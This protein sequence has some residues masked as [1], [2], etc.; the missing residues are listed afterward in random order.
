MDRVVE[1]PGL[2]KSEGGLGIID[3]VLKAKIFHGQWY[4]R[5]LARGAEP[6]KLLLRARIARI[7]AVPQSASDWRWLK[8]HLCQAYEPP[9]ECGGA[10]G[11][12]GCWNLES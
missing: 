1:W 6:W 8:I 3:P 12:A 9:R 10:S 2:P 4:L 11:R 7:Q 5:S